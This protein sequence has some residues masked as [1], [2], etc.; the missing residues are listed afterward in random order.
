VLHGLA[1]LAALGLS[2]AQAGA[3]VL[4]TVNW[5]ADSVPDGTGTGTLAGG[6]IAVTYTSVAG[7]NSGITIPG[8]WV[9]SPATDGVAGGGG[10]NKVAAGLGTTTATS[11]FTEII[12][13]SQN[14]TNPIL[15]VNFADQTSSMNFS[16][17]PITLLDSNNAS[18]SGNIIT[19]PGATNSTNDGFAGRLV[20]VFGP[21]NP[22]TFTYSTVAG[23][24]S[25]AFTIGL[26]A[27]PEPSV[28]VLAGVAGVFGILIQRRRRAHAA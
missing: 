15:L 7:G 5:A 3:Q 18:L 2:T 27:V 12:T 19:F 1:L 9:V 28:P 6:S 24:D 13:F 26:Q 16:A 4:D 11:P 22:I 21:A 23:F 20:G 14:M 10:A 8:N 17:H 25:V